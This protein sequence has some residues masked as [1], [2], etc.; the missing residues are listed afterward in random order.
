MRTGTASRLW[1]PLLL[2]SLIACDNSGNKGN[3]QPD[4]AGTMSGQS[5]TPNRSECVTLTLLRVCP[6]DGSQWL[7]VQCNPGETCQNGACVAPTPGPAKICTPGETRCATVT[8]MPDEVQVCNADGTA[9]EKKE[10]CPAS[11]KC[12]GNGLCEGRC[13]VGSSTCIDPYTLGTCN[14]TGNQIDAIRCATGDSCVTTQTD[15]FLT[16]A[17]K[18]SDCTPG[19]CQYICGNQVDPNADQERFVS[20]CR[21]TPQGRRWVAIACPT[22]EG[23]RADPEEGASCQRIGI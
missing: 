18:P 5:C 13:V 3:G 8:N 21:E 17:C 9:F 11:S 12:I 23:C 19:Y 15:P 6:S 10:S 16:A 22:N 20:E 1:L 14:A 7:A 2:S 4:L